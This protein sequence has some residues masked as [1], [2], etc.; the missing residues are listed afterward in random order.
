MVGWYLD[1][2]LLAARVAHARP[3]TTCRVSMCRLPFS[4]EHQRR[5]E[6]LMQQTFAI[7]LGLPESPKAHTLMNMRLNKVR[8]IVFLE[9]AWPAYCSV[10]EVDTGVSASLP[11]PDFPADPPLLTPLPY[12]PSTARLDLCVSPLG[13]YASP[14]LDLCSGN[15]CC[16]PECNLYFGSFRILRIAAFSSN[17][18]SE[19]R[20]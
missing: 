5:P 10:L 17:L 1:D 14:R 8:L 2:S 3:G 18:G 12:S 15:P 9:L 6:Q 4:L 11:F 13:T 20:N 19:T 16:T 7:V